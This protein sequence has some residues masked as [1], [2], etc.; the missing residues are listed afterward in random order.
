M[1]NHLV[2]QHRIRSGGGSPRSIHICSISS[3]LR[4]GVSAVGTTCPFSCSEAFVTP[5][6]TTISAA[7]SATRGNFCTPARAFG[8]APSRIRPVETPS[9][10]ARRQSEHETSASVVT[11]IMLI[12]PLWLYVLSA[13]GQERKRAEVRAWALEQRAAHCTVEREV[14]D[15]V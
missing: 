14:D 15:K 3:F 11:V 10:H 12:V 4:T 13:R 6:P 8:N 2:F 1:H 9:E 5:F 7:W